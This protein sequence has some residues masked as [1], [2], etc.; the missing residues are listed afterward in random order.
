MQSGVG[1]IPPCGPG[2][3]PP[4]SF[5]PFLVF[6]FFPPWGGGGLTI[7]V[8]LVLVKCRL[9]KKAQKIRLF[10]DFCLESVALWSVSGP[11]F[12]SSVSL[13]S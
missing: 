7:L 6:G 2:I 10:S 5:G 12:Y 1:Y 11:G 3:G 4:I 9:V 8:K 13:H